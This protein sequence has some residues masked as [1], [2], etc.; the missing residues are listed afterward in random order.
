MY[1]RDQLLS[2]ASSPL[3]QTATFGKQSS[4]PA[5]ISRS[6]E[7]SS[8]SYSQSLGKSPRTGSNLSMSASR[9]NQSSISALQQSSSPT[10]SSPTIVSNGFGKIGRERSG[11]NGNGGS[12]TA[13][14][15]GGAFNFNGPISPTKMSALSA[16]LKGSSVGGGTTT[17]AS[18]IQADQQPSSDTGGSVK[19]NGKEE[20]FDMEL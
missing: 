8:Y 17:S 5:E 7:K 2:L 10:G 20:Q 15:P 13:R 6:P 3:S 19:T 4:I 16:Q 12:T 9:N 18:S 1:S 14:S 11:S